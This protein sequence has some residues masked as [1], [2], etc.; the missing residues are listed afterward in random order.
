MIVILP[1]IPA[2]RDGRGRL[3]LDDNARIIHLLEVVFR[4]SLNTVFPSDCV[5]VS[6]G[7]TL[8]DWKLLILCKHLS[9]C[10]PIWDPSPHEPGKLR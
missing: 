8:S 6:A 9:N 7:T 5:S 1:T 4:F 3:V 2:R 10:F